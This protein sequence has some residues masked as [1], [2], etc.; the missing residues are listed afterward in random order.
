MQAVG[1]LAF[2]RH[3]GD[4][5]DP[6]INRTKVHLLLDIVAL[7]ICAVIAGAEGWEDIERYGRAKVDFLKQ[8]LKLP[9]GIPSHD[10]IHR[11]F[12]RV[13][14]EEFQR[15]FLSWTRA[16][17][18]ELGLKHVAI[19]GKTLRRSFD[20]A[21]GRSALHL[22]SAWSVENHLTL[23]Q[24]AVDGKSNEITAIP[25][26]LK[27]LELS[28]AIVTI[29]AMGCQKEIAEHVHQAGADFI[30][31]VKENQPHLYEDLSDHFIHLHETNF[32]GMKVSHCRTKDRQ[33]G[34]VE[35][36]DYYAVP[37][38]KHLRHREA[39]IGLCSVGQV[40][41]QVQQGEKHT[42]EVR[43]FISSLP[44]DARRFAE[45][46]RGHWG[47]ENSQHW[48][49]DVTFREDES[50]IRKDHGPENFALLRRLALGM[51]KRA[52]TK[53]SIRGN[54][55]IAGWNNDHLLSILAAAG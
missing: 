39:W 44:S 10:T 21:S 14:P 9:K 26:L 1:D 5:K 20:R 55:K 31:A 8:F 32:A 33:H 25:Q 6:R 49:L 27:L 11:L 17:A 28:G 24:A 16:L 18:K 46:V 34:R 35:V 23:A 40:V 15:C 13:K 30:L 12:R 52:K 53:G 48:V 3:F 47:I 41:T 22:V 19:D 45:A 4:L 37:V 38:P 42:D 29:D 54:R 51:I 36:R 50:R 43:L 2:F 7:A